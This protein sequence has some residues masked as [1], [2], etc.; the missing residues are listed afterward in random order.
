M[1][2]YFKILII[3]IVFILCFIFLNKLVSPKYQ[4]NLI[5]G[6]MIKEYYKEEKNH[7]V[8]FIGDCEV[9]ANFSPLIMYKNYGITS[10]VRGTSQQLIWQSYGILKETLKYEIPKVVVLNVN[11]LR[12]NEPV[13]EAYNHLTLDK[14]KWSQEKIEMINNSM[15]E[16]ESIFDYIFPI[17]RY[18]SRF[19]SLTSEDFKN[20]FTD[21]NV[22]YN[23]YLM[24]KNIKPVT[25]LPTKKI[26]GSYTFKDNVISY[27][28]KIRQ[29]CENNHIKL[30]LIKAPSVY[31]Y[32]YSEYNDQ[33][34]EYANT[35]NLDYYNLLE[36]AQEIGIDYNHDTYD[37]GLHLNLYGAEKLSTY[38]GD[39]L[40]NNYNLTDYRLDN[41]IS[42]IYNQK[43]SVYNKNKGDE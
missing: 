11:A 40:K 25:N 18:H 23:G 8:I 10:Y 29:L 26:L 22:T 5:E 41:H 30:V 28:D 2:K 42:N 12:Y 20:L 39:I 24:N 31:P 19:S 36:K 7:E 15:L 35:Y 32:W 1:K 9:Y 4:T 14:M 21:N 38:F 16:E 43:L 13:S 3:I 27:L 33:V 37:G 6:H 34:I 17:V